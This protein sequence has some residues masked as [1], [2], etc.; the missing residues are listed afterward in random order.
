MRGF[1]VGILSTMFAC[2]VTNLDGTEAIM[3]FRYWG[4]FLPII[5]F[6][7]WL[8]MELDDIKEKS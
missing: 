8:A 7:I 1:I 3:S 2:A 5:L 4:V 6:V